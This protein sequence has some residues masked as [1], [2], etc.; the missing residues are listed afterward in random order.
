MKKGLLGLYNIAFG[1]TIF[2]F[3]TFH[4]FF[5]RFEQTIEQTFTNFTEQEKR[6][7]KKITNIEKLCSLHKVIT[8]IWD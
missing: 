2:Y 3:T 8:S 6:E 4:S 7:T 5:N 1:L